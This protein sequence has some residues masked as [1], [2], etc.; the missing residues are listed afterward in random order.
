MSSSIEDVISVGIVLSWCHQSCVQ[1]WWVSVR[2]GAL[3]EDYRKSSG[4]GHRGFSDQGFEGEE[5]K[6]SLVFEKL[7]RE[8]KY[9]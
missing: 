6:Y 1:K 2:Q 8:E 9:I 4:Q 7:R 5:I 3:H